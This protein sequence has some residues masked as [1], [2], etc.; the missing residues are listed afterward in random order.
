MSISYVNPNISHIDRIPQI[1][2]EKSG[3]YKF[4]I[5]LCAYIDDSSKQIYNL[6]SK[7]TQIAYAQY[8]ENIDI[9]YLKRLITKCG[10]NIKWLES[11][12]NESDLRKIYFTAIQGF[13][14]SRLSDSSKNN[15]EYLLNTIF[16]DIASTIVV[17]DYGVDGDADAI[18]KYTAELTGVSLAGSEAYFSN[19]IKPKIT[20]VLAQFTFISNGNLCAMIFGEHIEGGVTVIGEYVPPTSNYSYNS[21]MFDNGEEK[22]IYANTNKPSPEE[23]TYTIAEATAS[24]VLE[25]K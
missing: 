5:D 10:I 2:K 20:G 9:N 4:I 12:I 8:S 6:L 14:V 17:T 22:I 21:M 18:M 15:L 25:L 19:Y 24:W 11:N 16:G 7:I 3:F 23:G 13:V 1:V